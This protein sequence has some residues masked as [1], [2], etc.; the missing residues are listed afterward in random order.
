MNRIKRKFLNLKKRTFRY[1]S[2]NTGGSQCFC[3]IC[4]NRFRFFMPYT[5]DRKELRQR[6]NKI[7]ETGIIASPQDAFYCPYCNS[8]SRDRHFTAMFDKIHFSQKYLNEQIKVLHFAPE[9]GISKLFLDAKCDYH[10]VDIDPKRYKHFSNISKADI[11]DI[12][13]ADNTFDMI[14]CIHVLEHI[15]NDG[16]ALSELYRVLKPGGTALLQTPYSDKLQQTFTDPS[17]KT[18]EEQIKAYVEEGHVRIYGLDLMQR[19]QEAGFELHFVNSK[20]LFTPKDADELGFNNK[21]DLMIVAKPALTTTTSNK[22]L[23]TTVH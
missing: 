22:H 17:V 16:K 11:T 19:Y 21:E 14:V 20:T 9:V 18:R 7:A 10:P 2:K 3:N 15:E 23:S 6:I 1:I 4:G 5:D 8:T 13:F 12:P